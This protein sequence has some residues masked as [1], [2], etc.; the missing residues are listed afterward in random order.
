MPTI[1]TRLY[2]D[3]SKASQVVAALQEKGFAR[4]DVDVVSGPPDESESADAAA[5]TR[6]IHEAGVYAKAAQAYGERVAG[7]ES[8]LVVRAPFGTA[9]D[10]KVTA[11]RYDPIPFDAVRTEVHKPQRAAPVKLIRVQNRRRILDG[12][13]TI[14]QVS[15][16]KTK[17]PLSA[18]FGL[19]V[20]KAPKR[21]KMLA[22]H[23][24]ILGGLSTLK[25]PA[26]KKSL[27]RS[28]TPLSSALGLQTLIR[29]R[30]SV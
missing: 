11:D 7:G 9:T 14:T 15:L 2:P 23:G 25:R 3:A 22:K 10:A 29:K 13:R 21:A 24:P 20:L 27:M 30:S 17:T 26:Q 8:L 19:P 12:H 4:S 18:R 1:I 5:L 16:V 28:S 6:V